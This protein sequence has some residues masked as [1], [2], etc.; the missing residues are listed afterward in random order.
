MVVD[1][2][3]GKQLVININISFHALTCAEVCSSDVAMYINIASYNTYHSIY[4]IYHIM[5]YVL[6]IMWEPR[7][8]SRSHTQ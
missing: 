3:L 8:R 7:E 1:T 5:P 4:P 2:T 6:Y